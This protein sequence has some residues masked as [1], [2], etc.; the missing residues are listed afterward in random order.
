ML[1]APFTPAARRAGA[2][3]LDDPRCD[4]VLRERSITDV[5][6]ANRLLGGMR[7]VLAELHLALPGL[8]PGRDLTLLD[9]GAGLG[10]IPAAARDAAARR[11]VQLVVI[12]ADAAHSLARASAQRLDAA[13]CADAR[14]LPFAT[15]SVDIVMCSQVLHHFPPG[16]VV[17]LLAEMDRVARMRVI[18]SDLRRNWVAATGFWIASFPMGFHPVSRADGVLSVLKGFT[19]QE[20]A[21]LIEQATGIRTRVRRRLGWRLTAQWTPAR[22]R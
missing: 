21:T 12:G 1:D 5:T 22:A 19:A 3:I 14:S 7:A 10:D 4:P 8:A 15:A 18:I 2:E 17:A 6:R 9:V 20:L 11:G 13:V 16:E